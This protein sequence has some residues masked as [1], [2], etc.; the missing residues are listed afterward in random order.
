MIGDGINDAP[1]LAQADIGIAMGSGSSVAMESSDVVIVKNN[2]AK[3]L[4]SFKL[5]QRLNKIIVQ[6]V[7]FSI[8]IIVILIFLNLFGWLDLPLGVV[9]LKD[10]QF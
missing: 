1:A 2:L 9:F 3:L 6:N 5:S 10:Q 4:Y 8:A 7:I